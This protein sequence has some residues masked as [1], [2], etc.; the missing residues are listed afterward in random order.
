MMER[1]KIIVTGAGGQLGKELQMAAGAFSTAGLPLSPQDS[2]SSFDFIFL[3]KED[4]PIQDAEQTL[5]FFER[6]KPDY[7]INCAAYT[8][9]DKAE[10]EKDLAFAVNGEA[11][12]SLAAACK[13]VGAGL[14]HI[15]TD[16]VFDGESA[17]PLKEKDPTGPINTYGASKLKGEQLAMQHNES[18]VIIRTSWVYSEFGNNFVK[19]M[20]RLMREKESIRVIND[21]I[22]SPTYAADLAAVI[23][24]MVSGTKFV[25]GIYHYSNEGQISW[26]DFALAIKELTHSPCSVDPIPTSQYPTPAKRP[27]YSLLDKG[28]IKT[29][30][31]ITIPEWKE[32]LA[33]CITR[34]SSP[35]VNT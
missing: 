3:S 32:S 7:C 18:T 19:T 29:T 24:R 23:L 11:V 15:S 10:T 16:Y 33:I 13:K 1:T 28:H 34:L 21:Q 31:G 6:T 26:Y 8:A 27:H 22:G 4:L 20:I 35:G 2:L 12:G 14:I 9:V 30:Y 5:R 25:P 17:E